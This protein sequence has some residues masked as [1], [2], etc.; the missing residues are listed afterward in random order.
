MNNKV[1]GH[2]PA[3]ERS[4]YRAFHYNLLQKAG[5][6]IFTTIA[7][8]KKLVVTKINGPLPHC[9]LLQIPISI[10]LNQSTCVS[11]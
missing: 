3:K 4:R 2:A 7:H 11:D 5:K 9:I 10:F 6:R 1:F 8:A